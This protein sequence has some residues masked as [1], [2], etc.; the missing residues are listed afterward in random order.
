MYRSGYN[1]GGNADFHKKRRGGKFCF[2]TQACR[3]V[4]LT[5]PCVPYAVHFFKVVDILKINLGRKQ[6]VLV[7][8][9][10]FKQSFYLFENFLCLLFN[11]SGRVCTQLT[12]EVQNTIVFH[13]I[14]I[15]AVAFK[16]S[17]SHHLPPYQYKSRSVWLNVIYSFDDATLT[18]AFS[19]L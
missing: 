6:M 13:N 5:Y 15:S 19:A 17:D 11:V 16:S 12:G 1:S 8:S 4:V 3:F 18:T 9:I 10:S 14:G 2:H 7:T